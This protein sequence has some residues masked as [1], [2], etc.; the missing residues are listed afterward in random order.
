MTLTVVH[1][2]QRKNPKAWLSAVVSERTCAARD[3]VAVFELTV[4]T[5]RYRRFCSPTCR[6]RSAQGYDDPARYSARTCAARNCNEQ[7]TP[8]E[9]GGKRR[10]CSKQ[11][12]DRYGN[13]TDTSEIDRNPRIC[14][15]LSCNKVFEPDRYNPGQ[16]FCAQKCQA[17]KAKTGNSRG[18][19]AYKRGLAVADIELTF[20]SQF[21]SYCYERIKLG[22]LHHDHAQPRSRAGADEWWNIVPACSEC[23]RTKGAKTPLEFEQERAR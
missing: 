9:R 15:G 22:D 4:K 3:C 7:F 14:E 16:R 10:F 19:R 17:S 23:N 13:K 11:C 5:H 12:R 8:R 21:C 20:D 6:S 1:T 2:Y 18:I